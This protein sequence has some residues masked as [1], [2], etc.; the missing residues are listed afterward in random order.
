MATQTELGVLTLRIPAD[1]SAVRQTSGKF[2]GAVLDKATVCV[3]V[4]LLTT[5]HQRVEQ[6]LSFLVALSGTGVD[7]GLI[8]FAL[9]GA[10]EHETASGTGVATGP[11]PTGGI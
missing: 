3:A 11:I 4:V 1:I 2:G 9:S 7:T 6:N 10:I 5:D 8:A